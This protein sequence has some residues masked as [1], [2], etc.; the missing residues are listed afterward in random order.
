MVFF[1]FL[2][3]LRTTKVYINESTLP[4]S[5]KLES[6]E[7]P[8]AP[9]LF[10][11]QRLLMA[12]LD[13]VPSPVPER[14]HLSINEDAFPQDSAEL[15]TH[16]PTSV[17]PSTSRCA[18]PSNDN[19]P[20]RPSPI[21]GHPTRKSRSAADIYETCSDHFDQFNYGD[22]R[23]REGDEPRW[24]KSILVES[25]YDYTPR[26]G[27]ELKLK[28]G[29]TIKVIRRGDDEDGWWYGETSDGQKGFFP[30]N[31]VQLAKGKPTEIRSDELQFKGLLGS[32]GFSVVKLAIYRGREVAVKIPH[33]KF[34]PK[35]ILAAV[36]EEASIFQMLSHE[37]IVAMYGVVVGS[38][39]GLVLELCRDSLANVCSSSKDIS[40]SEEIIGNWGTQI[41]RGMNYLHELNVL[42]R[43]LK[44]ANILIKEKVCDCLLNVPSNSSEQI[45]HRLESRNGFCQKCG[46]AAL[47]RLTLKIADLGLSKKLQVADC[48]MSFVGTV[49]YLAPEVIRDRKCSKAMDVW[50]FGLVL[51]EV[52]T[53]ATPFEGLGQGA[54]QLQ[55]GTFVKQKI[56]SS[57]PADLKRIIESCW[58]DD[59]HDRP[60][61]KQLAVELKAFSDK[62]KTT[63][64]SDRA[65]L[66]NSLNTLRKSMMEEMTLIAHEMAKKAAELQKREEN[67]KKGERE[68]ELNRMMFE[69]Q[70]TLSREA[71]KEKPQPPKRRPHLKCSDIS[72]PFD[73]KTEISLTRNLQLI[74]SAH[75]DDSSNNLTPSERPSIDANGKKL[76]N[77]DIPF[78]NETDSTICGFATLPRTPKKL[79]LQKN[80]EFHFD[81]SNLKPKSSASGTP[82]KS[83]PDLLR[84]YWGSNAD[85]SPK[86]ASPRLL[87][88]VNARRIKKDSVRGSTDDG[89]DD[90][91]VVVVSDAVADLESLLEQDGHSQP[92]LDHLATPRRA[93]LPLPDGSR[94]RDHSRSNSATGEGARLKGGKDEEKGFFRKMPFFK[95][96]DKSPAAGNA[97]LP[98]P[99]MMPMPL[100]H[101]TAGSGII[102]KSMAP[103]RLLSKSP[104][105]PKRGHNEKKKSKATTP[106]KGNE[107][108]MLTENSRTFVKSGERRLSAA[109]ASST[110]AN[111]TRAANRSP[112]SVRSST[113]DVSAAARCAPYEKLSETSDA[114]ILENAAY[115]PPKEFGR[116]RK[117]TSS[118][119]ASYKPIP[120]SRSPSSSRASCDDNVPCSSLGIIENLSYRPPS[121][122]K[123]KT[124]NAVTL[125]SPVEGGVDPDQ[126]HS[127]NS[128]NSEEGV[129]YENLPTK[130]GSSTR[131]YPDETGDLYVPLSTI[132]RSVLNASPRGV[133]LA[134]NVAQTE[135][136]SITN[137]A[138]FIPNR[139][140]CAG[141]EAAAGSYLSLGAHIN[142]DTPVDVS[143][144]PSGRPQ[145]PFTLDLNQPST[146]A[147]SGISTA[148]S[149]YRSLPSADHVP[150]DHAPPPPTEPA[151][152]VAPPIP[153]RMNARRHEEDLGSRSKLSPVS[154]SP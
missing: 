80:S 128:L 117:T 8:I 2:N 81:G 45:A 146:P 99:I 18:A 78:N 116:G 93:P 10:T 94:S 29:S 100:G 58:R 108:F 139:C 138:Y 120:T 88:R 12:P 147:E 95:S 84:L 33:S 112:P 137:N 36:R 104:S 22:V 97:T 70:Q 63:D 60:T 92:S 91:C 135:I 154:Q 152:R 51:W 1:G 136:S 7:S 43:D 24:K 6:P 148:G 68:L 53:G 13:D 103:S 72:K 23:F 75:G 82:S 130:F 86:D 50:S 102:A 16:S 26:R 57:C 87:H 151:P 144:V 14:R 119:N 73:C 4:Q 41:A 20:D 85:A 66:E 76:V 129:P 17:N 145:R 131:V 30:Q 141:T 127:M 109:N 15:S 64:S 9:S 132:Q 110:M 111:N 11:H 106:D 107:A 150:Q 32:G 113:D 121:D 122:V 77:Q 118:S 65:F 35:E 5:I 71:P 48:R 25:N 37:N 55:I 133:P 98:R 54:V 67:L 153:P 105:T 115:I 96:K 40:L 140:G 89:V 38:E 3:R 143:T 47:N 125:D 34:S 19:V 39:P 21:C 59:P 44:A 114:G 61:F 126:Y 52:L 124:S 56:P 79:S 142:A 69:L 31:H 90:R 46:G 134:D 74:K 83:T 101:S 42:H 123:R 28:R 49:P 27:D 149:S 62:Y